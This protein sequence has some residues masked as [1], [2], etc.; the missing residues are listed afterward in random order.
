VTEAPE[1]ERVEAPPSTLRERLLAEPDRAPEL[2][3]LA[4]SERFAEP[5]R[6]WAAHM[7]ARGHS[8][9]EAAQIAVRRHA[10]M[11][12]AEGAVIGFGGA[13]TAAA[14]LVALA[15]VQSRMIFFVAAAHGYDPAHPMRPAELLA[16]HGLYETPA[17]AREALDGVGRS[18]AAA[19]A[20]RTFDRGRDQTL[21]RRLLG[22]V[23]RRV[24]RRVVGRAIPFL[25][26]PIAAVQNGRLTAELGTQALRYYGG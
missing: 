26:S 23:G 24:A 3:A 9:A 19:L 17:A 22:F 1:A 8:P 12:R 6:R 11:A 25:S 4:A 16:L 15:W 21:R 20:D 5:A 2:I 7:A 14:D 13:I 10:R 18:L